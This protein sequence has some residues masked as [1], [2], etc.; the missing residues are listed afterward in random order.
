M[1]LV[2]DADIAEAEA[3]LDARERPPWYIETFLAFGGWIAGLLAAG[4]IFAFV[5]AN[6]MKATDE[7][8]PAAIAMALGLGFVFAGV[9]VGGSGRGDFRRHFAIA[10]AGA[11][12]TAATMSAWY[13]IASFFGDPPGEYKSRAGLLASLFLAILGA[14]AAR[15]MRD[16]ILTFLVASA[17]FWIVAISLSSFDEQGFA[18]SVWFRAFPPASALLGLLLF[19]R[20]VGRE[21]YAAVGAALL[22]APMILY[23]VVS[24]GVWMF[25]FDKPILGV[26]ANKFALAAGAVYCLALIR[27]RYSLANLL[28][29]TAIITAAIWF[30][31]DAG[32][33]AALILLAGFAASHR[34]LAAVGVVALAW[35]IAQFY[36]ALSM[37]LLEKSAILAGLGATTLAGVALSRR[38]GRSKEGQAEAARGRR[39]LVATLLFGAFLLGS[40][41]LVERSVVTLE[42][43]FAQGREI[44]LPLAPVDPRSLLQGDYMVLNFDRMV[45]PDPEQAETL[46]DKGEVF[47]KLDVGGVASFSRI[48]TESAEPQADEIRIDYLRI[49]G[50][51]RYCPTSYFFQEGE[52]QIFNAARYA[53][54]RVAPDGKARLVALADADRRVIDPKAP[55]R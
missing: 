1:S 26:T 2:S 16:A 19:T 22:I 48:A 12:L 7:K 29:G 33:V 14:A 30:L 4:A 49:S 51:I 34:G 24:N 40:L 32:G 41:A 52:A 5:A 23:Q 15:S 46:P 36:A 47:L 55:K 8:V 20:P 44:Y 54:L 39:P 10:I 18:Q 25:G 45:F 13:L 6:F 27:D 3:A 50:D 17:W 43:D 11:G 37:S 35:F 28:A 42:R 21:I 9:R 53:V 31:P 38:G